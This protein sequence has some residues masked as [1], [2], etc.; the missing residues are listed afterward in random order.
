MKNAFIAITVIFIVLKIGIFGANQ[1]FY[2]IF[3]LLTPF[4]NL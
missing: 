4:R 1:F 3:D 2:N